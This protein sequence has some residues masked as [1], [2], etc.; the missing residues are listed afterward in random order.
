MH[1]ARVYK[2][3][4]KGAPKRREFVDPSYCRHLRVPKPKRMHKLCK[5]GCKWSVTNW[6][7]CSA[8]CVE[9]AYQKR[10]VYCES[11][12]GNPINHTYCDAAHKPPVEKICNNCVR[13]ER[14]PV[15][16][17]RTFV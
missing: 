15:S 5:V 11:V 14:R 13:R 7:Q 8:N 3:E 12:L 17:V 9:E 1:C 10:S 4:I 2:P 6:S 16:S